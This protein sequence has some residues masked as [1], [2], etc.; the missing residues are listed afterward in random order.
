[1][2][3]R[4]PLPKLGA[5]HEEAVKAFWAEALCHGRDLQRDPLIGNHR[6]PV[7]GCGVI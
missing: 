2:L 4:L 3:E 1:M 5:V 7:K 6:V